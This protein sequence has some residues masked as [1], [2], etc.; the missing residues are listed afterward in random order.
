[1]ATR[2]REFAAED[3]MSEH[4]A[5]MWNVEKD[6]WLNSSGASLTLLDKPA[7]FEYLQR[8]L[9]A[10]I[11]KMPRLVERVV[12]GFGRL[13]TP[14]WAPDPEFD[15]DYHLREIELGG[16]GT[17]R[18]L[19]D[20][21]TSLYNEPLDRT[22]PLWRFLSISGLADGRGAVYVIMHHVIADGIGQIRMAE[23]YQQISAD[24]P[25]PD[26]VDLHGYLAE[27]LAA[28]NVKE[29]GGDSDSSLNDAVRDSVAHLVRRQ[30]GIA[31]R[32]AGEVVL[33][34]ADPGRMND[35]LVNIAETAAAA[36]NQLSPSPDDDSHGSPLW[37]NRSRHRHLESVT[38]KVSDLKAAAHTVGA[39][40]NDA[41][42]AGLAEAAHRYHAERE[43]PAQT[44]NSSFVLSTRTD[45][46]AGGNA[47]T[48][49]PVRL[50]G[51]PMTITDRLTAVH[52]A[53]QEARELA[54]RTGG[55]GG[56]SGIANL[57]PT[58]VVTRAARA[59]GARIDFATS[60]MRGAPFDLFC[61]GARVVQ[62]IVMGPVAGTGANI[63][64]MSYGD[65]FEIGLFIDPVAIAE[66]TAFRD[67]VEAAFADMFASMASQPATASEPAPKKRAAKKVT[68]KK[69]A[70]KKTASGSKRTAKK[71]APAPKRAVAKKA[72]AKKTAAKKT[73]AKKTAAKKPAAKKPATKKTAAKKTAAK[74]TTAKKTAAKKTAA[75]K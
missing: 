11:V 71:T 35:K 36:M 53:T 62:T 34:P 25:A 27:R 59:Q 26:E 17:M 66:P 33:W 40:L 67:H 20:L 18:E 45:A 47:F 29:S 51:G 8:T 21:T 54:E 7:D 70:A 31:R 3:R 41:F 42:M 72:P 44:F 5:L 48:P 32:V 39:S 65:N 74:K 38:V 49:V 73:T 4:E 68:A 14:A 16:N 6:P 2:E 22:R 37:T 56:L 15:L 10:A 60:N 55:V 13:S 1:M 43:A 50:P 24:Q 75:K 63:T 9:R 58:S 46:K 64:A 12:P 69:L 19:L 28:A 52:Q 30:L 23:M 61:A 57:L